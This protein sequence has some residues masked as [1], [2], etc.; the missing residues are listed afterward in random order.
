VK[1]RES[2]AHAVVAAMEAHDALEHADLAEQCRLDAEEAL[3]AANASAQRTAAW[4]RA[5]EQELLETRNSLSWKITRPVRSAGAL[6]RALRRPGNLRRVLTRVTGNERLRRLIIPL[7][8]RYPALGRRVSAS[9][10]AIKQALPTQAPNG[11]DVPEELRALPVSVRSVL[12][13]LHRARSN[14]TGT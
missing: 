13:D 7:L 8:L 11:I 10:S 12:A 4:A 3:A 1:L 14:Q 5:M 6:A 2:E 9:L